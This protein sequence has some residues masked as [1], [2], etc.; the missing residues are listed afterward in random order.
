[1]IEDDSSSLSI[2]HRC[3]SILVMPI[4]TW[5]SYSFGFLALGDRTEHATDDFWPK[6]KQAHCQA[7]ETLAELFSTLG[8]HA[9]FFLTAGEQRERQAKGQRKWYSDCFFLQ[10][11]SCLMRAASKGADMWHARNYLGKEPS[12]IK[13]KAPQTTFKIV[14]S[15]TKTHTTIHKHEQTHNT[16]TRAHT[17]T[18]I[19]AHIHIHI[20]IH[21]NSHVNT[22]AR[23]NTHMYT[24]MHTPTHAQIQS[25]TRYMYATNTHTTHTHSLSHFRSLSFSLPLFLSLPFSL[26]PRYTHTHTHTHS[27]Y[28][29]LLI[30]RYCPHN[31]RTHAKLHLNAYTCL[32][33]FASTFRYIVRQVIQSHVCSVLLNT[34]SY[35]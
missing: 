32:H 13:T 33:I 18:N 20:H 21:T 12:K 15:P 22:Q 28:S 34:V 30:E 3:S 29:C 31:V 10:S 14:R 5:C 17:H 1:M 2:H 8:D 11:Y 35:I 24:W 7:M 9:G 25:H 16:H 6:C 19:D 26:A 4:H 23:T 27:V